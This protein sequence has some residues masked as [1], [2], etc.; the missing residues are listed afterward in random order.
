MPSSKIKLEKIKSLLFYKNQLTKARRTTP[1]EQLTCHGAACDL[2]QPDVIRCTNIGGS[3]LDVEWGCHADLPEQ[4]RFGRVEVSCEGWSK[5]GDLYVYKES[6]GERRGNSYP[7][8]EGSSRF[9][10]LVFLFIASVFAWQIY[11]CFRSIRRPQSSRR[12]PPPD[13]YETRP[14]YTPYSRFNDGSPPPYTSFPDKPSANTGWTP[15]FWSGLAFGGVGSH[16]YNTFRNRS[17]GREE[18]AQRRRAYDWER[19]RAAGPS[20]PSAF[21]HSSSSR[22]DRGE[23]S[24][25]LGSMREASTFGGSSVR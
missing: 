3:G 22:N 16:L 10:A 13:E 21:R 15:G 2:Y 4:L 12:R 18:N 20:R 8:Y 11:G 23:G 7:A 19:E 17:T 1:I 6:C 5:P 9:R 14:P 24:S 25:N